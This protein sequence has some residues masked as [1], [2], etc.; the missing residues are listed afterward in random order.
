ME[1]RRCPTCTKVFTLKKNLYRHVRHVHERQNNYECGICQKRFSRKSHRDMHLRV[2]SRRVMVSSAGEKNI[3][4]VN[5]LKKRAVAES[6]DGGVALPVLNNKNMNLRDCSFCGK[7][8]PSSRSLWDHKQK[9]KKTVPVPEIHERANLERF[10]VDD[11]D[12]GEFFDSYTELEE[13]DFGD[14]IFSNSLVGPD[15][16]IRQNSFD[17]LKESM[18]QDNR[19]YFD[20]RSLGGRVAAILAGGEFNEESLTQER[21]DALALYRKDCGW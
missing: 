8:F 1:E 3:E 2:C 5:V 7:A 18:R 11:F 19:A 16:F 20:R 14:G 6:V 17:E 13:F 4:D 10:G 12:D 15:K 9:C 21:K